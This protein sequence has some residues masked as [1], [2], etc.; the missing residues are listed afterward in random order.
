MDREAAD[1]NEREFETTYR[2][3]R[4]RINPRIFLGAA[5]ALVFL[6]AHQ[7][8]SVPVAILVSFAVSA[9][10]FGRSEDEQAVK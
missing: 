2:S 5:P 3:G 4:M 10:V 7:F 8:T 1:A 9:V 6:V